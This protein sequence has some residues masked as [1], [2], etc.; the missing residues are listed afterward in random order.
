MD[1]LHAKSLQGTGG[2]YD[3]LSIGK[4]FGASLRRERKPV[5]EQLPEI[6]K[7]SSSGWPSRAGVIHILSLTQQERC[8]PYSWRGWAGK[9]H[10][11]K[12]LISWPAIWTPLMICQ[13]EPDFRTFQSLYCGAHAEWL[14]HWCAVPTQPWV[15]RVNS[16]CPEHWCTDINPEVLIDFLNKYFQIKFQVITW[17][18]RLVGEFFLRLWQNKTSKQSLSPN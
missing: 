16:V 11:A 10:Y 7:G 6:G 3:I 17:M 5:A 8:P 13:W 12:F 1:F 14:R 18:F 2:N 15:N 4:H 9:T